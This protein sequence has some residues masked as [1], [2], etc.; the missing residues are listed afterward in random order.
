MNLRLV[1]ANLR[2]V[3]WPLCM[4][5][6]A[7]LLADTKSVS[8]LSVMI[9]AAF[10]GAMLGFC[11]GIMFANRAHRRHREYVLGG[12][13]ARMPRRSGQPRRDSPDRKSAA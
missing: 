3:I 8:S 4:A 12:T 11:L 6:A 2:L 7:F 1:F 13:I 5:Y 9:T 10:L